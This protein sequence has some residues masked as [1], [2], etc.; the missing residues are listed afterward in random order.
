[1]RNQSKGS[2]NKKKGLMT[3]NDILEINFESIH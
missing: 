2:I 3:C 1:M